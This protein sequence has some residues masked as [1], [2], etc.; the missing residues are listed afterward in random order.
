MKEF[1]NKFRQINAAN[2]KKIV[3]LKKQFF[4]QRNDLEKE[5]TQKNEDLMNK[6]DECQ[7]KIRDLEVDLLSIQNKKAEK[8]KLLEIVNKDLQVKTRK[9]DKKLVKHHRGFIMYG[10]PGKS[11]INAKWCYRWMI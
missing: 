4:K 1:Q 9:I 2:E 5:W 7:E 10:P 6:I 11:L 8:A 3:V